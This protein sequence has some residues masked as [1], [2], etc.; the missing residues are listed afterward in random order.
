MVGNSEERMQG[1]MVRKSPRI[2]TYKDG[3]KN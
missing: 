2:E 1:M 3:Q